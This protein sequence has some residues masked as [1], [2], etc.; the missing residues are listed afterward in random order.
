MLAIAIVL[1]LGFAVVEAVG[2]YFA[3]SLALM[4][5]AGHMA[6]DAVALGIS[7]FAAWIALRPPSHQHSYGFGRAEIIAAWVSSLLMLIIS[8]AV[9][10]EAVDRINR[11]VHVHGIPVMIIASMGILLN[12]LIAWLL[13]RS[14]RTLNVRAALLH[15]CSDILGTLTALISGAVIYFTHWV[16][17]D[18]ILSILIG[19]LIMI[20]SIR[21]LK[22]SMRI[23]MEG[24][25][26]HLSIK[27]VS[28]TM[29][30]I[31]RVKSVH[32]VHI[33]T[34]S[35]GVIALSAHVDI[36]DLGVWDNV[37]VELKSVLKKQ[38]QIDHIT[39]QPERNIE[40]CEPCYKP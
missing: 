38:Y 8:I 4:G 30:H 12:L 11:P 26:H 13:S 29:M 37:L 5:D 7:A 9:I 33:W 3:H 32:D 36:S 19:I 31:D 15:V 27:Q 17:I 6:S 40:E 28:Q 16:K 10:V 39:L 21:L 23:L 22:E 24:V 1:T 2:G 35:S 14:E 25:P 20:S 18:P 34:L